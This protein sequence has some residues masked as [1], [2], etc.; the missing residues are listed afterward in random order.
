MRNSLCFTTVAGK[1][2]HAEF[3]LIRHIRL[4]Q[5][6]GSWQYYCIFVTDVVYTDTGETDEE[7]RFG[8]YKSDNCVTYR[9][10]TYGFDS[11]DRLCMVVE[12]E[13]NLAM[14]ESL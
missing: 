5:C 1:T 4:I 7:A 11:L 2:R 8:L 9:G 13:N 10:K 3:G 14:L 6:A 12:N